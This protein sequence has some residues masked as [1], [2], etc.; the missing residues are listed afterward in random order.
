M[1]L[2]D[3]LMTSVF[4]AVLSTVVSDPSS[5]AEA[6]TPASSPAAVTASA[7][8]T[9]DIVNA[10]VAYEQP[11]AEPSEPPD[12]EPS[13]PQVLTE[14]TFGQS[15]LRA[16][17]QALEELR[18]ELEQ[19]KNA[20]EASPEPLDRPEDP[21]AGVSLDDVERVAREMFS[22]M[23]QSTATAACQCEPVDPDAIAEAVV[24]LM[25]DRFVCVDIP[26]LSG[27]QA[28]SPT[29]AVSTPTSWGAA[30]PP[31]SGSF[32]SPGYS[33]GPGETVVSVREWTSAING[34]P[35]AAPDASFASPSRDPMT[36]TCDGPQCQIQNRPFAPV[37][38]RKNGF[39]RRLFN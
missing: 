7:L 30:S 25:R 9:A 28:V 5:P 6:V 39:F 35:V 24:A 11:D 22:R 12:A 13:E 18:A 34:V 10:I 15:V 17:R 21:P 2:P 26:S 31:A 23:E 36:P 37:E 14:E 29:P 20:F 8:T 16:E 32:A 38:T 33:V 27:Q 3:V 19:L 4:A 1:R